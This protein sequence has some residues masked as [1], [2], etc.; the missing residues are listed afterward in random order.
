MDD[1]SRYPQGPLP[2]S[3]LTPEKSYETIRRDA[4]TALAGVLAGFWGDI[5][6]Q[7]R[8]GGIANHDGRTAYEDRFA[9]QM[10]N[11]RALELA[12]RYREH[13]ETAFDRWRNPRPRPVENRN[14]SLMSEAQLE[15]HLAGQQI[16]ELLDNQFVLSLQAM[17]ERLDGLGGALGL[18]KQGPE[19]NPMRPEVPVQAFL[20][21]LGED[22]LTPEVR[23]LVFLQLEKRLAKVLE[24][25]Y[26]KVNSA[27]EKGYG[28]REMTPPPT[29]MPQPQPQPHPM[30][31]YVPVQGWVPD[32]G[33][34][35][36]RGGAGP[37]GYAPAGGMPQGAPGYGAPA[38]AWG[39]QGGSTLADGRATRYREAVHQQLRVWRE[40]VLSPHVDDGVESYPG[41]GH[42]LAPQE[43]VGIAS[44][45]QGDDPAPFVR[46]LAGEDGRPLSAV[47]REQ[48]ANGSRQLGYDPTSTRFNEQDEDAID[49][50]GIMIETLSRTHAA[51][52]RS[53]ALY[54]RLVVPYVKLALNDNGLFE[55][56]AHPG[57]KL[58]EAL[59]EACDGN[60]GESPQDQQTLTHAELAV[61]R[62]IEEYREDQ[63]I[64]A[65]AAQELRDH[66]D[67]QRR[68]RE[69]AEQRAAEAVGGRERLVHARRAV[70][71]VLASRLMQ[72]PL[73][74][75]I[76]EF[77][78]SHWR[79]YLVQTWL[80]D[81]P[82]SALYASAVS[83]GDS[84]IQADADA[85]ACLG[86]RVADRILELQA[87]LGRCYA[88]CG[89]DAAGARDSL[90]R[91]VTALAFPELPRTMHAV[92]AEESVPEASDAVTWG[93]LRVVGGTDTLEFDPAIAA[94]MKRLRVGQMLRLVE[95]DGRESSG[96]IAWVS[97]L[98][99][100][101]LIVNRR[102]QRKLVVSPEEL[103]ALAG[104]GRVQLRSN[105]A[106]F[107]EAMREMWKQ[108]GQVRAAS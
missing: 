13:L 105:D 53:R 75:G 19:S 38:G 9:I 69:I 91:I 51:M 20:K 66:L 82:K 8:I 74:A 45:L 12:N 107:E 46:A 93:G 14:M 25:L 78:G 48:I 71:D 90:A 30:P 77:L 98:T 52:Q 99:S 43:L 16:I 61:E 89:L 27:L 31:G 63:A 103:A 49:L 33:M 87:P 67:Q 83:V 18:P 97:P 96:K 79:H 72:R 3:R 86:G 32:G 10:L 50:V 37:M 100:R 15:I 56:R 26:R 102:G 23:R 108:L 55:H 5:E 94:R 62:V 95:E 104:Q 80:R 44:M 2:L 47:I 64:F 106:P 85:A 22:D 81:G 65:L 59:T 34:V 6:E 28:P 42:V 68:V 92:P 73:T 58:L 101:F 7:V 41:H 40:Q 88:A 21:L 11:Q 60:V 76:A 17:Q 1:T 36:P 4:V 57:R 39:P 84:L 54:G 35:A 29:P 70:D 24:S